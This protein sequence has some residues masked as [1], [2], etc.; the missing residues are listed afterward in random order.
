LQAPRFEYS[1]SA[2]CLQSMDQSIRLEAPTV[3][4]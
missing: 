1:C 2:T 3:A 4:A